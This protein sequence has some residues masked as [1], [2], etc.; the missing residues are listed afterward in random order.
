MALL[1]GA[2]IL[3][4][5]DTFEFY[6]CVFNATAIGGESWL[7]VAKLVV[8]DD[9]TFPTSFIPFYHEDYSGFISVAISNADSGRIFDYIIPELIV[10]GT[11]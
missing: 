5:A 8:P 2:L 1:E 9:I 3:K 6:L 7:P 11:T 4:S 10:T